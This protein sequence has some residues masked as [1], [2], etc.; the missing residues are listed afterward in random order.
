MRQPADH[1]LEN[2]F[3]KRK[4]IRGPAQAK[5][6]LTYPGRPSVGVCQITGSLSRLSFRG[7]VPYEFKPL[8]E[9]VPVFE[10]RVRI[11][12]DL[13]VAG[14]KDL[15]DVLSTADRTMA[16]RATLEFQV[17]RGTV[18]FPPGSVPITWTLRL[19]PLDHERPMQ[20]PRP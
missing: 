19:R 13:K 16:V 3:S 17:C 2:E 9:T 20:S 7:L 8:R 6:T 15:A 5:A 18:C 12:Q 4:P 11:L 1:D 14:E 10:G